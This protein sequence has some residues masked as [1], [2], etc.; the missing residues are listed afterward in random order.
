VPVGSIGDF[1]MLMPSQVYGN[2]LLNPNMVM[3]ANVGDEL[4]SLVSQTARFSSR[5][6]AIFDQSLVA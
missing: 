6:G 2:V 3:A 5:F 4:A 1:F